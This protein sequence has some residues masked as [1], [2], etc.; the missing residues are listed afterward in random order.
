MERLSRLVND[1]LVYAR[2]SPPARDDI[3]VEDLLRDVAALLAAPC[4]RAG[5]V[6]SVDV[7]DGRLRGDRAQLSQVLV[8]LALN[9]VQ[10]MEG[11]AER[12]LTLAGHGSEE[13]VVIE[14]VDSGPGIPA[15]EIDAVRQAFFS[16]RK[17]GTG[18]GLAIAERIVNAHGGT[19]EL[20]N[21]PEGGLVARAVL[22][23]DV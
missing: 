15:D 17:G 23:R 4:D 7:D 21:R 1:F 6:L 20:V 11:C 8:N 18:L 3:V 13:A 2:P 12:R 14:V 16:K 22:P 9:A 19:L 5:V 10:A